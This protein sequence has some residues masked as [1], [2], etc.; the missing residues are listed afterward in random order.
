MRFNTAKPNMQQS[1]EQSASKALLS[2]KGVWKGSSVEWHT[3]EAQAAAATEI[4]QREMAMLRRWHGS[5][6]V[7]FSRAAKVKAMLANGM[8]GGQIAQRLK[9]QPGCGMR[10]VKKDMAA[11]LAAKK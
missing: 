5:P 10:Q 7:N 4:D 9:G 11:L 8:T 1:Q 2:A 3:G 6:N